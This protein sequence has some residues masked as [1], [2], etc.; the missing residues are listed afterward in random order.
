MTFHWNNPIHKEVHIKVHTMFVG[1]PRGKK[2]CNYY[3]QKR[4]KNYYMLLFPFPHFTSSSSFLMT[5]SCLSFSSRKVSNNRT[6]QDTRRRY[7]R[8]ESKSNQLAIVPCRWWKC[9]SNG[10]NML[11]LLLVSSWE[12][13]QAYNEKVREETLGFLETMSKK[14]EKWMMSPIR[15]VN[16]AL[17]SGLLPPSLPLYGDVRDFCKR[18]DRYRNWCIW[19]DWWIEWLMKL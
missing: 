13:E 18:K 10:W 12:K 6:P 19:M 3:E 7:T 8:I 9:T 11:M 14:A 1:S 15:P 4:K 5:L 2:R 16:N 17:Y